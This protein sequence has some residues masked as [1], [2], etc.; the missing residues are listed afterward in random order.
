MPE[1][2]MRVV[3]VGAMAALLVPHPVAGDERDELS[4]T[5]RRLAAVQ[6]VLRDARTDGGPTPWS[7]WR[8]PP[9]RSGGR[10]PGWP[11]RSGGPY[12]I[13]LSVVVQAN[14]LRDLVERASS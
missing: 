1:R 2:S 6:S 12:M 4:R 3:L 5:R 7:P 14:D 10:R 8:R 11:S 13:G 9:T